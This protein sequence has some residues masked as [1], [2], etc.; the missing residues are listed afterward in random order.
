MEENSQLSLV[1]EENVAPK[2]KIRFSNFDILKIIAF[3]MV[4][5]L[6][7][8]NSEMG[9][10]LNTTNTDVQY[11]LRTVESICII[12]VPLFVLITGYFSYKSTFFSVRKVIG[13]FIMEALYMLLC[14][15]LDLIIFKKPFNGGGLGACFEFTNYYINLYLFLMILAPFVNKLF[16]L[17]KKTV[18]TV[19][20]LYTF[21]IIV[22]PSLVNIAFGFFNPEL[23]FPKLYMFSYGY[24]ILSFLYYY[25]IGAAIHTYDFTLKKRWSAL[26]YVVSLGV[27]TGLSFYI[28][29]KAT[30]SLDMADRIWQYDNM[31]VAVNAISLFLLFKSI[32][33]KEIKVITKIAECSLGVFILHTTEFFVKSYN[34]LFYILD[35]CNMGVGNA[36]VNM[37]L[38]V[39]TTIGLCMAADLLLRFAVTPIKN[40][41]YAGK[42]VNYHLIDLP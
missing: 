25:L 42:W 33:I 9:G 30:Y 18:F 26:I 20:G 15:L 11:F 16:K 36:A 29:P 19:L 21:F 37:A 6:H 8:N 4:V 28:T 10:A 23:N 13:L 31:I 41:L 14:F 2:K 12:A 32:K 3:I 27:L 39:F 22:Y 34:G 17:S 24:T 1:A 40:R 38:V 7:Y 5:F 35:N